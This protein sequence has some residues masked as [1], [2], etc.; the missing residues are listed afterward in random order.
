MLSFNQIYGSSLPDKSLCLTF[1]D[2]PGETAGNGPGPK[3][4]RLAEY[5]FEQKIFATF[6]MVGK[7]IMEYP[8][9]LAKISKVG[10][11]IGNHTF[12]HPNMKG[13]SLSGG[14]II[15]EIKK[16]EELIVNHI[17]NKT[18]YFRAPY[19]YWSPELSVRL[20]HR[21]GNGVHYVGPFNW[22]IGGN[23]FVLWDRHQSAEECADVYLREIELKRRGIVL[24]HDCTA[25]NDNMKM[26]NRTFETIQIL[27]PRLKDLGYK[28]V[29]LD[30]L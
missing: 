15:S 9:H 11:L 14:D 13:L 30:E 22:D 7:F 28:F 20:N 24:M 17:S 16:T 10:H 3:T 12:N 5:L 8:D 23:D 21:L 1:D 19:G 27:V 6:F 29:R 2:G 18:V 4:L 26:N 25:D